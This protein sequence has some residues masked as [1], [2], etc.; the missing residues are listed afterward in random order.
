MGLVNAEKSLTY[1]PDHIGKETYNIN[2]SLDA[3]RVTGDPE[4]LK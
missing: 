2:E 1:A 4:A 3:P